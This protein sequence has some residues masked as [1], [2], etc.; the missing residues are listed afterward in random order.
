MEGNSKESR[1]KLE[2]TFVVARA[3]CTNIDQQ[4]QNTMLVV[5]YRSVFNGFQ[6]L[7]KT[8]DKPLFYQKFFSLTLQQTQS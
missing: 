1:V 8:F 5:A 3:K 7:S 2:S 4:T 6:C